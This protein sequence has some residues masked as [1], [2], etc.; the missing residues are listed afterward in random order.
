MPIRSHVKNEWSFPRDGSL[1]IINS[2]TLCLENNCLDGP[3][4][5]WMEMNNGD[6]QLN[7]TEQYQLKVILSLVKAKPRGTESY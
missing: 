4:N 5:S 7:A 6:W 2:Y 1:T 3:P